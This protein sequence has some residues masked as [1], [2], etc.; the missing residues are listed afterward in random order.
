MLSALMKK[1]SIPL[2]YEYAKALLKEG[3]PVVWP[4]DDWSELNNL[5]DGL[6]WEL[7]QFL[8]KNGQKELGLKVLQSLIVREGWSQD[9]DLRKIITNTGS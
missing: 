2:A 8:M 1:P 6:V 9:P 7:G 4:I 5:D 3:E